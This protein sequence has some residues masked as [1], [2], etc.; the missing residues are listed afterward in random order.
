MD[1]NTC[2]EINY[3]NTFYTHIKKH[4][5]SG[6]KSILIKIDTL[7]NELREHP[8][9]GTGRPEPLTADKKGQWSRRI[10]Q[11]HRLIYQVNDTIVTVHVLSAFGHY[12]EK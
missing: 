1:T 6:Q 5:L 10:S 4:Q 11:K 7:L 12:E 8:Y 2:Y 9:T 3:T